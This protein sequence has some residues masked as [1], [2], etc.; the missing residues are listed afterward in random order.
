MPLKGV[1]RSYTDTAAARDIKGTVARRGLCGDVY[2]VSTPAGARIADL[3]VETLVRKKLLSL[4]TAMQGLSAHAQYT[5]QARI[6]KQ[7]QSLREF[8]SPAFR[9][10]D[11][12]NGCVTFTQ[13]WIP[14]DLWDIHT[15]GNTYE[16]E[17]SLLDRTGEVLDVHAPLRF[18]TE[19]RAGCNSRDFFGLGVL[20]FAMIP[21]LPEGL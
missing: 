7:G 15:P 13:A 14:D 16:V 6:L 18:A 3:K 2:L 10:S 9:A 4:N 8:T 11:L 19:H 21:Q 17:V 20:R 5:L 1:M 12:Q